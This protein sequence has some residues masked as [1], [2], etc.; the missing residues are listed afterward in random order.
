MLIHPSDIKISKR[1]DIYPKLLYAKRFANNTLTK[2]EHDV[3]YHH[4]KVYNNFTEFDDATKVG[5]DEFINRFD[6]L[7]I[8]ASANILFTKHVLTSNLSLINGL[9]RVSTAIAYNQKIHVKVDSTSEQGRLWWPYWKNFELYGNS[10]DL[11][12]LDAD[13]AGLQ[14]VIKQIPNAKVLVVTPNSI[15][16]QQVEQ[17]LK[18]TIAEAIIYKKSLKLTKEGYLNLNNHL[19]GKEDWANF[20]TLTKHTEYCSKFSNTKT[21]EID[22]Y[23]INFDD[24][25]M[26]SEEL[27]TSLRT[28]LSNSNNTLEKDFKTYCHINDTFYETV[29]IV[30]T[31]FSNH[32]EDFLNGTRFI[33]YKEAIKKFSQIHTENIDLSEKLALT[34]SSVLDFFV[35][36]SY[37]SDIDIIVDSSVDYKSYCRNRIH[38]GS[39]NY[40]GYKYLDLFDVKE[41]NEL[42]Y[43]PRNYFWLYGMKI[44]KPRIMKTFYENRYKL[45]HQQKDYCRFQLLQFMTISEK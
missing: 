40:Y 29:D 16:K 2:Y 6:D 15:N 18:S 36:R 32:S 35:E 9:H 45:E 38:V 37:S 28:I 30:R 22:L 5:Y 4:T 33:L 34:G 27:K 26:S 24:T 12:N 7:L 10:N 17:Q 11:K 3:Y 20:D 23:L 31:C 1:F 39:Y 41:F 14:E 44:I 13:Y 21:L 8:D 19:Y 42:I 25:I 43:D